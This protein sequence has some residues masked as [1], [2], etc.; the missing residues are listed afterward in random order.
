VCSYK[1]N[2][3][4]NKINEYNSVFTKKLIILRQVKRLLAL[5]E[6]S[7]F[8]EKLVAPWLVKK[9]LAL[10]GVQSFITVFTT[11]KK[12]DPFMTLA[13]VKDRDSL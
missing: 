8:T 7:V 1:P 5:L 12:T 13:S 4:Q 9:F 11:G 10:H 2:F 3:Y 6:G